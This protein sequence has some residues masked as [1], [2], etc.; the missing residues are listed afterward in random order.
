MVIHTETIDRVAV[1]HFS[2]SGDVWSVSAIREALHRAIGEGHHRVVCDLGEM[3]FICSDA[4]GAF[5][6]ARQLAAD[7]GGYVRLV[8]PQ[9]RVEQVIRT[10]RVDRLFGIYDSVDAARTAGQPT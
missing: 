1:V 6:S 4:L 2:G 5:I 3:D 8:N 10:T 9:R 7:T